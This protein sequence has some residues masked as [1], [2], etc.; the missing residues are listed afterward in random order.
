MENPQISANP[1][2]H[3]LLEEGL[4]ISK[5]G[6]SFAGTCGNYHFCPFKVGQKS[7]NWPFSG[8]DIS[9]ILHAMP[10]HEI[11]KYWHTQGCLKKKIILKLHQF[12]E[13]LYG[14]E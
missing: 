5:M 2:P 14:F 10:K 12:P 9:R 4:R 13:E 6:V 1:T 11:A 8:A 7:Q 3:T